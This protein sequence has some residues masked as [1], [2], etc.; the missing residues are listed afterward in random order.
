MQGATN[1]IWLRM[2][3]VGQL[4]NPA[5][6]PLFKWSSASNLRF[7]HLVSLIS[8]LLGEAGGTGQTTLPSTSVL[9]WVRATAHNIIIAVHWET[10][11]ED[12]KQ[13]KYGV[14]G[15]ISLNI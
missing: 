14:F 1:G 12:K 3:I 7:L 10:P 15:I 6:T 2:S 8:G 4:L 11:Q 13:N 9:L 5:A